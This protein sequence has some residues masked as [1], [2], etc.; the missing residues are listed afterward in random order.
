MSDDK[1]SDEQLRERL[2]PLQYKVTREKGTERPFTGEYHDCKDDGMYNC[3]CCGEALFSSDHKFDSGT[4]WPSY[5]QPVATSA[6]R[7]ETD[8]SL[9]MQRTEVLCA[10]C[11]AHLGHVFNDGPPTTGLRY[12]INSASLDLKQ[13]QKED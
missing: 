12:C 5:T 9:G 10:K 3:I 13:K 8:N 7:E 1:I 2:T 4:G 11:D 6:V